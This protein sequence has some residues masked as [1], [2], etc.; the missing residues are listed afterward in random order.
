M[1]TAAG[2]L[3]G[4]ALTRAG[5]TGVV[6]ARETVVPRPFRR[7]LGLAGDLICAVAVILC[8]P[9]VILAIAT[10]VAVGVGLLLWIT[11]LV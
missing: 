3:Q 10:P 11:G 6:Q 7:A 9:F 5:A 2:R 8:I 4:A 1:T